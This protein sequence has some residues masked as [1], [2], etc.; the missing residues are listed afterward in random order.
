M[1]VR[2]QNIRKNRMFSQ[3][4]VK[5]GNFCQN[6]NSSRKKVSKLRILYSIFQVIADYRGKLSPN[7]NSRLNN[8]L[9][10]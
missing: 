7:P 4:V 3:I 5:N 8:Y 2:S 6:K 9:A 10:L 1:L